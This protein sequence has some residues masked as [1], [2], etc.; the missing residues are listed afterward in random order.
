MGYSIT[1]SSGRRYSTNVDEWQPSRNLYHG[2]PNGFIPLIILYREDGEGGYN[3]TVPDPITRGITVMN[4]VSLPPYI[5]N[6]K[7]T[8]FHRYRVRLVSPE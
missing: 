1:R 4:C 7:P 5:H 6:L 8:K 3:L 2:K